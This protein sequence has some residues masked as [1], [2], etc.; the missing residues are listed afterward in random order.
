MNVTMNGMCDRLAGL[1]DLDQVVDGLITSLA[2][3]AAVSSPAAPNTAAE[4]KQLA[5]LAALLEVA[6]GPDAGYLG[7]GWVTVLRSLSALEQLK[8]SCQLAQLIHSQSSLSCSTE[9]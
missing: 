9:F 7:S 4:G 2:A 8:V 6:A 5:A 3:A 1:L